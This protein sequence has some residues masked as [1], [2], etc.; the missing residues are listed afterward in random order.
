MAETQNSMIDFNDEDE[1]YQNLL[2]TLQFILRVLP[3]DRV[4][5]LKLLRLSRCFRISIFMKI[6]LV[7]EAQIS[8]KVASS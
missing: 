5:T 6:Y 8:S 4:C 3:S 7:S 2:D 1:V